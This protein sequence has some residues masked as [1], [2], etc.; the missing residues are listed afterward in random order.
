MRPFEAEGLPLVGELL[1]D[2]M[3]VELLSDGEIAI[4]VSFDITIT[5]TDGECGA[6]GVVE[7]RADEELLP[8]VTPVF[9]A[10][11]HLQVQTPGT[12]EEGVVPDVVPPEVVIVSVLIS[13]AHGARADRVDQKQKGEE[14]GLFHD[15][16]LEGG[17]ARIRQMRLKIPIPFAGDKCG[18]S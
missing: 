18:C 5:G 1:P 7:A 11:L 16:G 3:L 17:S 14:E 6:E 15:K 13:S 4:G 9:T 12:V 8:F 10:I 2:A